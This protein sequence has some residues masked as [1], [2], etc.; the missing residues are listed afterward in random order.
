MSPKTVT[1]HA[2]WPGG[3]GNGSVPID[4]M[5][6]MAGS[7]VMV[8]GNPNGLSKP[9]YRFEGRAL[10]ASANIPDYA[11]SASDTVTPPSFIIGSSDVHLYGVWSG[12]YA[13]DQNAYDR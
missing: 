2:N 3:T 4:P 5:Q 12:K 8:L 7:Q 10:S 9:G 1:Y 11:V 6:Y 13:Y